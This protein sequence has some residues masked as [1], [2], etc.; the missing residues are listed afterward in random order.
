MVRRF[1]PY[2][3]ETRKY[4]LNIDGLV[5]SDSD[6]SMDD[7]D[8]LPFWSALIKDGYL[9][10]SPYRGN[11]FAVLNI[12]SGE[13]GELDFPLSIDWPGIDR[14]FPSYIR[15]SFIWN[16]LTMPDS[17]FWFSAVKRR[18]Y[19]ISLEPAGCRVLRE[20]PMKADVDEVRTHAYGFSDLAPWHR[21]SL[22]ED[23]FNSLP[24]FIEGKIT[25]A[26]FSRK[27]QLASYSEISRN[28][29]GTCGRHVCDFLME[30]VFQH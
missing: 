24:D 21:Y 16:P 11:K 4:D 3:G 2:T 18:L 12:V 8:V 5:C 14:Y 23:A 13:A 15:G 1:N 22:C 29:D 26:A 20:I 27:K 25:G 17:V 6:Q 30:K 9:Y 19:E 7:R 28:L 10:M